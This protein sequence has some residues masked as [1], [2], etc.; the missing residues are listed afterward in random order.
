MEAFNKIFKNRIILKNTY[1]LNQNKQL[2]LRRIKDW[3]TI[4]FYKSSVPNSKN[5]FNFKN[6]FKR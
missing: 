4:F 1:F 2:K 6:G 5:I 3:M